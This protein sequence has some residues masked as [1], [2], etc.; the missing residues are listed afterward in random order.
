MQKLN[1]MEIVR[2]ENGKHIWN[3]NAEKHVVS[4]KWQAEV[5]DQIRPDQ[6]LQAPTLQNQTHPVQ[7]L[8]FFFYK[9]FI[10]LIYLWHESKL[11]VWKQV[12]KFENEKS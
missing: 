1:T 2:R 8:C 6:T 5:A 3:R 7:V 11:Q 4:V 9:R 12:C 10:F